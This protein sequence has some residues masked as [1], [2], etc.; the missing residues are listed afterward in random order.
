TAPEP[1]APRRGPPPSLAQRYEGLELVG[2]GG[3]GIVYRAHD[4]RL[5]RT[6]ALKLIKG[7]DPSLAGR[8]LQEARAQARVVHENVCRVYEAGQAD[9]EP[10]V[11]MQFIQG[12]PLS[13]CGPK[14]TLEQ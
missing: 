10:F 1:S 7:D 5:G 8:F 12:E 14:L 9:G 11:A 6:V 13:R 4:P 2:E 3:M